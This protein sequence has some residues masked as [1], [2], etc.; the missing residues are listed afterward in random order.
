MREKLSGGQSDAPLLIYIG[1]L[2]KE[3][4]IERLK[5]VIEALPR[6]RLAIVGSGPA[7]AE[8]RKLFQDNKNVVFTGPMSGKCFINLFSFIF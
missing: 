5:P 6:C 7:E 3:K 8:L 2:G 4:K 1:R